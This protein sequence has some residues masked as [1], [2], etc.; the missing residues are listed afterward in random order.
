[1]NAVDHDALVRAIGMMRAE[2]DD[3]RALID[4]LLRRNGFADAGETAA[5]Y[6]QTRRLCTP[7]S[8]RSAGTMAM[9]VEQLLRRLLDAKLSKY[10]PDVLAA[11]ERAERAA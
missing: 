11:L 3:S 1:M 7:P 10:E 8:P 9:A 2:S 4:E 5:Y 6:C